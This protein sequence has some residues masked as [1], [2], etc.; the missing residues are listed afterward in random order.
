MICSGIREKLL[1]CGNARNFRK[2]ETSRERTPSRMSSTGMFLVVS[3][4]I[5]MM[6]SL[7]SRINDISWLAVAPRA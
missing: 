2:M 3:R 4:S 1:Q 7:I 6:A 5:H